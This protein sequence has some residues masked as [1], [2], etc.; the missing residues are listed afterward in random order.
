VTIGSAGALTLSGVVTYDNTYHTALNGVNITLKQGSTVVGTATTSTQIVNNVPTPGYYIFTALN[1][2]N[3]TM[4][5]T[6]SGTWGGVNATDALRIELYA[7]NP[8]QYP[9]PGLRWPAGDVDLSAAVDATDALWVKMRTV[10]LVNYFPAGNWVFDNGAITVNVSPNPTPYNFKG[11]C[12]GDVNASY[13]PTSLKSASNIGII[14]D[15]IKY[16]SK[17]LSF[18]YE[19]KPSINTEIGAMTLF[20]G[21]DKDLIEIEGVS[22]SLGE[23]SYNLYDNGI[24]G[25][26][27]S[28]LNT[29][30]TDG[31]TPI[32][33]IQMRAKT[34]VD[35]PTRLFTIENESE[36]AN[37]NAEPISGLDLKMAKIANGAI[38]FSMMNYPNPFK[39]NTTIVYSLP[40]PGHVKLTITNMF[41]QIFSTL[42][43]GD[44]TAGVYRVTVDPTESNLQPGVYMYMIEVNGITT[45]YN[46]V[47]KMIFT[48]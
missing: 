41:G 3:Y 7:S 30:T 17:D 46:K 11:L 8:T 22:S 25:L 4:D 12:T 2:G 21:Y 32:I 29:V 15:G 35:A 36:F 39:N 37:A 10:N 48:R 26:A 27:W 1:P 9:L 42:V 23:L 38:E 28:D 5:V 40:E 44:Q 14:D 24:V 47:N 6:Y 20:L 43:N 18:T 19:I 33:T 31:A 34:D 13:I 16:I 45:N